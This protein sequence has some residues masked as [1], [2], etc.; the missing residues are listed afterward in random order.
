[1]QIH[2]DNSRVIDG[3]IARNEKLESRIA[4][5]E[6]ER[7]KLLFCLLKISDQ[8]IGEISMNYRLDAQHIGESIYQATG[9]TN[10]ELGKALKEDK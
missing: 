3:L 6:A 4:E 1:M 8:C 7:K 2:T 9:K 10:P 5:L